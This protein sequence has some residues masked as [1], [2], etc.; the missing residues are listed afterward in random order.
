MNLGCD[1][2]SWGAVKALVMSFE[3]RMASG[4][5]RDRPRITGGT[6]GQVSGSGEVVDGDI[7]CHSRGLSFCDSDGGITMKIPLFGRLDRY[8]ETANCFQ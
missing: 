5:C 1:L 2:D 8:N 4:T 6:G 3:T 7:F